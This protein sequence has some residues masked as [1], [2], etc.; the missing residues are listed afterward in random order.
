MDYAVK[1]LRKSAEPNLIA[2]IRKS[3]PC[4]HFSGFNPLFLGKY[5]FIEI[6]DKDEL[7]AGI[8]YC[9]TEKTA[10]INDVIVKDGYRNKGI[11][12]YLVK[13]VEDECREKKIKTITTSN[14]N[15]QGSKLAKK[16]SFETKKGAYFFKNVQLKPDKGN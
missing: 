6:F 14:A 15:A 4:Y 9:I 10:I 16:N 7:I 3:V 1:F 12:S 11:G 13:L 2:L 5:D 8:T